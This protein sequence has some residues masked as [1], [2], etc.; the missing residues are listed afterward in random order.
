MYCLHLT[1]PLLS[2]ILVAALSSMPA[3]AREFD[4]DVM[5]ED[6]ESQLAKSL[7]DSSKRIEELQPALR[8]AMEEKSQEINNQLEESLDRVFVELESMN[9]QLREASE[10][11]IDQL[12]EVMSSDEIKELQSFLEQLDED[13]VRESMSRIGDQLSEFLELT[14]EQVAEL[15]PLVEEFIQQQSEV[16]QEFLKSS[17]KDFA[18]FRKELEKSGE[19]VKQRMGAIL[20][21]EQK[22]KLRKHEEDI[23]ERIRSD[24]FET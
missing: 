23:S 16:L 9:K 12:D 21:E 18:K 24:I 14:G 6:L 11:A 15:K 20:S 22:D 8:S 13:A 2:I 7:D 17:E 5:L 19:S 1:R 3:K 10:S 4:L